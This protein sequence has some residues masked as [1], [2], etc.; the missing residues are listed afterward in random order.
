M[1]E[2]WYITNTSPLTL[3]SLTGSIDCSC[4]LPT[5]RI[6]AC[7]ASWDTQKI[8][9]PTP[10]PCDTSRIISRNPE[11]G[12]SIEIDFVCISLGGGVDPLCGG[13]AGAGLLAHFVKTCSFFVIDSVDAQAWGGEASAQTI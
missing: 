12:F 6:L 4:V 7:C 2:T 8:Y 1:L 9:Y 11:G 13:A 5:P 3:A 10:H